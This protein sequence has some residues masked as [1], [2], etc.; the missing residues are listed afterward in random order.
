MIEK[1]HY[2][3]RESGTN[4]FDFPSS[5]MKALLAVAPMGSIERSDLIKMTSIFPVKS[6]APQKDIKLSI[7]LPLIG[8]SISF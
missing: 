7:T 5:K 6:N 1:K 2:Q 4:S 8:Y 3:D